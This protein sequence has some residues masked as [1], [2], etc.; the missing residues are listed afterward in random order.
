M[1]PYA[2]GFLLIALTAWMAGTAPAGAD[3]ALQ[4]VSVMAYWRE[5]PAR[6]L[7]ASVLVV[8]GEELERYGIE[9]F[10]E[11][12]YLIP[13]FTVGFGQATQTISMRGAG[14]FA[15]RSLQQSVALYIDELYRPR[16]R[17]F[18]SPFMD[19]EQIEIFRGPQTVAHGFNATAGAIHVVTR[20]T[21]PGD[22]WFVELSVD[23]EFEHGG[24]GAT[25]IVGGS[26][27]STLGVR[28]GITNRDR[29]GYFLNTLTGADENGSRDILMRLTTVWTPNERW[30][31]TAKYEPGDYETH[32]NSGE[33]FGAGAGAVE[34]GDGRLDWRRHADASLIDP[35]DLFRETGPAATS[36]IKIITARL[37]HTRPSGTYSATVEHSQFDFELTT[38]RDLTD[39][40]LLDGGAEE[41]YEMDNL[42]LRYASPKG[43]AV[44][45]LFGYAFL[46]TDLESDDTEVFGHEVIEPGMALAS[47]TVY[48]LDATLQTLFGQAVWRAGERLTVTAGLRYNTERAEVLRGSRCELGEL[49]N[50]L[51]LAPPVLVNTYCPNQALNGFEAKRKTEQTLPEVGLSW[52]AREHLTVYGR[53]GLGGKFGGFSTL[54]DAQASDLEYDDEQA[55]GLEAGFKS[56]LLD[57]AVDLNLALFYNDFDDLQ[58]AS[59]LSELSITLPQYRTRIDNGATATSLG[60]E[61]DGRWAVSDSLTLRGALAWLDAEYDDYPNAPCRTGDVFGNVVVPCDLGGRA[62]PFAPEFSGSLGAE[63]VRGLSPGVNLTAGLRLGFSDGYFTEVALDPATRQ[64]SWLWLGARVGIEDTDG[65]WSLSLVAKN[66]T[67]EK[68]LGSARPIY[69]H[70]YRDVFVGYLE[71]PRMILLTGRYRF[72]Q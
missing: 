39:L 69:E 17:Q 21:L 28:A 56:R 18:R 23:D 58:T 19:V 15:E 24:P 3:E 31:L 67:D 50:E 34:S 22:R 55:A 71:P 49:G 14:A 4:E 10:N 64:D 46:N 27:L 13:N 20:K 47:T 48:E 45:Y 44:D 65:V 36:R 52:Q 12:S 57:G 37:D 70:I 1:R 5:T 63:F 53:L 38:D 2:T 11:L 25:L 33:L 6:E 7:P 62:L 66:L 43:G 30:T 51:V 8:S 29:D 68:I 72:G 59:S 40:S 35:F 16:S 54:P 61:L 41:D 9:D 26:P 60:L 32:G 42:Y